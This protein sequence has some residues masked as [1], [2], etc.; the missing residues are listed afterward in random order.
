MNIIIE[1]DSCMNS[2]DCQ[3]QDQ[4]E[5][6]GPGEVSGN[7]EPNDSGEGGPSLLLVENRTDERGD[8]MS[9]EETKQKTNI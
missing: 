6:S 3:S 7:T 2:P 8:S 9:E 5:F 1:E 4:F